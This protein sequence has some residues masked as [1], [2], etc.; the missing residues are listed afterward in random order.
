MIFCLN[1]GL[2]K[3][4]HSHKKEEAKAQNP[5]EIG[6][7]TLF[8]YFIWYILFILRTNI[9]SRH[10]HFFFITFNNKHTKL[11]FHFTLW[12]I[13]HVAPSLSITFTSS[14]KHQHLFIDSIQINTYLPRK[15]PTHS[16][17]LSIYLPS[18]VVWNCE[19]WNSIL[20][21]TCAQTF[22]EPTINCTLRGTS[23]CP[24]SKLHIISK[25][26]QK[27]SIK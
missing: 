13:K 26:V 11:N 14:P 15:P 25:R 6:I 8:Q 5:P 10:V 3:I 22:L 23:Q 16:S 20:D 27:E 9:L 4:L 19:P 7:A 1:A 12:C 18:W 21:S 17:L 2:W 24:L